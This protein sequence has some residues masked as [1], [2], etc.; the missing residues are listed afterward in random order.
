MKSRSAVLFVLFV[1][2]LVGVAI[3]FSAPVAGSAADLEIEHTLS[4]SPSDDR[5]DVETR[6]SVPDSTIDLEVTL[7]EGVDVYE[8]DG[9]ERTGDRTYEWTETTAEPRLR[10]EYRGTV[11]ES[12]GDREGV[13]FV[14][15][16]GWAIV[17]TPNIGVSGTTT[18]EGVEVVRKHAVDGEGAVGTHMAYLGPYTEHTGAAAGQEFRLVVPAAADL[19]E[20]PADI[21]ATLESSAERLTIGD[22]TPEV[23]VV[24]APTAEHTWA[25][26]G[27]QIGDSGDMWVRDT[28]PLGTD[29]DTWIHEYVHTR[30]AYV[31]LADGSDGT[32]AETRWTIEGMADYYAALLPYESG[33]IDYETFADRLAEGADEAYDDVRLAD[34]ETWD[35]TD[36]DY[37]RGALVFAHLDR[38]L[39]T[40]ADTTLDAVVADI[41]ADE[42]RLTQRRFLEAIEAAG[43]GTIRAD[44]E[45]YTETT[46]TPPIPTRSE[47]VEAFGGPDVR[48]SIDGLAVSGS[49]RNGTL[50][51][52]ALVRGETLTV[53]ASAENVGP[54]A[55]AFEAA[56]RVDGET[57]ATDDG[58]LEPEESSTLAFS[59]R[60]DDA[61]E[62]DVSVGRETLT[63]T[64]E[65]PAEISV[66]DIDVAPAE[67]TVR[68]SVTLTATVESTANRPADGEVVFA[69]D[70]EPLDAH[71]VR[72]D[73]GS[74][75][76]ETTI[77]FETEGEYTVSAGNVSETISVRE[78]TDPSEAESEPTAIE[79]QAGF[80]AA[81]ALVA[82]VATAVLA[83]D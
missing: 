48:Y 17:R 66:R 25:V 5:I 56:F 43:D 77:D 27:I 49:Y 13:R 7:P 60:F 68:E 73:A 1:G 19:S 83:R 42:E 29:R 10:Y 62:F 15:A 50:G 72:V 53:N 44:A 82:L 54:D 58:R 6:L 81:A 38:Q 40:G 4:Q 12:R 76:V 14:V 36:A 24:A 69:V 9:F 28:E 59:H 52:P 31:T 65:E 3:A 22:P 8:S 41:N 32:T 35:G 26:A 80:G 47:H 11:R 61:G 20:E 79:D 21:L 45:R 55:G 51:E 64:V 70:G 18:G 23:F 75:T 74:T 63:V 78:P 46:A 57:L 71:T 39:R 34:P 33:A 16:D 30:Q 37:D 2:C 67:P